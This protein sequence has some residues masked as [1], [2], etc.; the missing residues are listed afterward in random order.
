MH[1]NIGVNHTDVEWIFK[2][3]ILGCID[4]RDLKPADRCIIPEQRKQESMSSDAPTPP[5]VIL[6]NQRPGKWLGVQ[7]FFGVCCGRASDST[8]RTRAWRSARCPTNGPRIRFSP[9]GNSTSSTAMPFLWANDA[10]LR[11]LVPPL[12]YPRRFPGTILVDAPIQNGLRRPSFALIFQLTVV[13]QRVLG[14][15][16]GQVSEAV[17]EDI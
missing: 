2:V 1:A 3:T 5:G 13:G 14:A 8:D 15:R 4:G 10:L 7:H 12:P 11:P 16:M 9:P 6:N 17:R